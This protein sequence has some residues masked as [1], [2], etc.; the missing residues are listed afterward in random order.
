VVQ[1]LYR[2]M[3]ATGVGSRLR[4][5]RCF[6]GGLVSGSVG[7]RRE[8]GAIHP[9]TRYSYYLAF[10]ILPDEQV[11]LEAWLRAHPPIVGPGYCLTKQRPV[12]YTTVYN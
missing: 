6:G 10:G 8:Y 5:H 7:M 2:Q 3:A 9:R 1:E 11:Q 4:L 12:W